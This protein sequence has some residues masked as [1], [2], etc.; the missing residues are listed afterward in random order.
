MEYSK[1]IYDEFYE[2][3]HPDAF[4]KSLLDTSIDVY[5][6][7]DHNYSK[8]L[9]RVGAG[10]LALDNQADGLHV[11][12]KNNGTTDANDLALRIASGDTQGMSFTFR[13]KET[14]PPERHLDKYAITVMEAELREVCF[15]FDPA[16]PTTDAGMR[17][18]ILAAIRPPADPD[19][20]EKRKRQLA[21]AL[22]LTKGK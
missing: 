6:T 18:A 17:S 9:G 14:G 3:F 1:L 21:L 4:K 7:V 12:C 15:T 10:T 22:A 8:L 2:R 20:R 19:P 16:Y 11:S 13:Y 5:C